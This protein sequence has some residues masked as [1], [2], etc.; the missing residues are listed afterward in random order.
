MCVCVCVCVYIYE[1][2][3]IEVGGKFSL[4]YLIITK[5]KSIFKII[6]KPHTKS[7]LQC[8]PFCLTVSLLTVVLAM[9][10]KFHLVISIMVS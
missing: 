1:T 8:T 3:C 6:F 7:Y 9:V 10:F 2:L 4:Y 5:S